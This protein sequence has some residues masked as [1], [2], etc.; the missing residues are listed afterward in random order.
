MEH[1]YVPGY[2]NSNAKLVIVGEAP[3]KY[4][5]QEGRPF[6]GP[7]GNL[8]DECL[9]FAG[10]SRDDL[11]ITNVVKHRPPNNKIKDLHLIGHKIEEYI[12]QLVQEINT[13]NPNCI[14]VIGNTALEVLTGHKGIEKYRGSIL[15][16]KITS[17][18]CVATIHPAS[19]LHSEGEAMRSWRDLSLI[20]NDISRAAEQS[21]FP[22]IRSP[23]RTLQ[24][25]RNSSDVYRFLN[26]YNGPKYQFAS[27]D[28]ETSR[29]IP[30]C[31]SLAFNR[32]NAI[33]IPL[34]T[35]EI[36]D[37]DLAYIWK[38]LAEFYADNKIKLVAQNGKF[39]EKRCRQI[40][41]KWHDLYFDVMLAW[42]TLYAEFPKKLAVI[43]SI[44]T[45]EPY[46][47]DEGSEYD[48]KK[49]SFDRLCLYNAKDSAVEFECF[50]EEMKLFDEQPDL[51]EFFFSKVMPL[52]RLYSNMEDVGLLVDKFVRENLHK[53]YSKL[54]DE[55]HAELIERIINGDEILRESFK[56]FNPNSPKQVA[57]LLF[58]FLKC[59]ARKDTG[60][61]TLKSLANNSVKDDRRKSIITGILEQRKIRKT[62]GTYIE[63]NL[64]SDGRIRTETMIVG[65]ESGRTSTQVRK[66]P[67]VVL[68]EGLALQTMTKHEDP[69]LD[70]G[71]G[72]LRSMFIADEGYT[73]IE[74]DLSQAEDRVVCVLAKDWDA[75]KEYERTK[76]EYNPF[77]V[78]DDR[79]TKTAIM[80]CETDFEYI[81]DYLRQI[82]KM[83]RH[84][85][86][87]A[88]G[89]H[90]LML[91]LAG[92]GIYVSEWKSGKY[93]NKFHEASP[94]IR[95]T[96]HT[97]IQEALANNSCTLFSPHGRKRQF[98]NKWGDE[99]FKEAYSFIPQAT[100]SDQTKF[101]LLRIVERLKKIGRIFFPCLES[102]DSFLALILDKYIATA[103]QI[104]KEEL[105]RP[106]NFKRCTL[107]RDYDLIIPCEIKIGKRWIE[108]SEQ[109]KD[110]MRK[111]DTRKN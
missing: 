25:A 50:E 43:A 3:G 18:K 35:K 83:V 44:L 23:A 101:A 79:H 49:H 59:P 90:E 33:S 28:V 7:A 46:Y 85:G 88:I 74:P 66:P 100:I 84:A 99:L 40:G 92:N 107:S 103:A 98:F 41:L 37:H 64:S 56:K 89:K 21:L 5:E 15:P 104:I 58:G 78:K 2:G 111:Y 14:L 31:T 36:P 87:L 86:N 12:P 95:G 57:N 30:I 42:A 19:L 26:E 81:T 39:D 73:F 53:K 80:V 55:K 32:W 75:L 16:S 68:Q 105:E 34:L 60:E 4:E 10:I 20:K 9:E 45:E 96:F 109:F 1:P 102:H 108:Q 22:E 76:F 65:T 97:G 6:V 77:G 17:H 61:D 106:I 13:I 47:K 72:D 110:G 8:L 27:S 29:T 67:V 51:K 48:A 52:H 93:I 63:A 11:Y 71:G 91:H 94:K 62:I 54:R 70:A 38:L 69:N 82:G 24:I